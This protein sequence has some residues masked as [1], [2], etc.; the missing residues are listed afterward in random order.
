MF[1][2]NL[3]TERLLL[4]NI[5]VN[6]REFIF[7]MFSDEVVNKY[8]FDAEPLTDISGADEIIEFYLEPEPRL[9]HR[10]IIIRK[11]DGVKMGTCGFHCWNTS[12]STVDV[13]Y[14]LKEQF[15]GNGYMQEAIK[16][17]VGFAKDKMKI[18]TISASIYIENTRSV[19]LAES[20][21]LTRSGHS[22]ELFRGKE[23]QHYR[24][25]LSLNK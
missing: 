23:Y 12:N 10:W 16:E 25:S 6:D 7:D 8:L 1:F 21:G 24:Y 2:T 15:W 4:K 11:S 20:L 5:D 14:D 22:T 3:E 17:I 9:Q 18:E 13:G 19:K